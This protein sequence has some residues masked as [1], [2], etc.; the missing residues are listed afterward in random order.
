MANEE[1]VALLLDGVRKTLTS[2]STAPPRREE[3]NA[4]KHRGF[5]Y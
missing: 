3:Q 5:K 1:H 4:S 2:V